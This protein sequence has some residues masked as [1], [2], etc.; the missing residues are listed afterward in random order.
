M[1]PVLTTRARRN[2]PN[3][4]LV[5]IVGLFLAA[6]ALVYAPLAARY[7]RALTRA[8]DLG[9]LLD[10]T[11]GVMPAALPPRVYA[12]LMENSAPASEAD[13][14]AQA[15]ALGAELVQRLSSQANELHLD[16]VVAEPGAVTQQPGWNEVRAH[17]RM[18]GS[19]ANYLRFLDALSRGGR[20]VT[21]ERFAIAPEGAGACDIEVWVSGA[22]LKRRRPTP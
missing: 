18:R 17:L 4:V 11:R 16:V 14:R 9:V 19:W 6:Q 21:I 1:D 5:A 3:F 22:T 15:G 20:L 7:R 10:P 2:W 13:A 12:F 8:G